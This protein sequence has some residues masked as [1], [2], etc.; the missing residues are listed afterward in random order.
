MFESCV[1][2][3]KKRLSWTHGRD[4]LD[5]SLLRGHEGPADSSPPAPA[6]DFSLLDLSWARET[7]PPPPTPPGV[8]ISIGQSRYQEHN[9]YFRPL[10]A[11]RKEGCRRP[12][13]TDLQQNRLKTTHPAGARFY[14][15]SHCCPSSLGQD[16]E[17]SR[18]TVLP[19]LILLS[20]IFRSRQ[21]TQQGHG[22][23]STHVAVLHL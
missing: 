16:N 5:E 22:F 8:Q 13:G 19:L 10:C 20:F 15:Y 12:S 6:S 1:D 4:L 18:G 23:T 11:G 21:R 2:C 9:S 17:P 7:Q 14:I 3:L